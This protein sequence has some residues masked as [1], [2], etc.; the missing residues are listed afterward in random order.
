MG[1]NYEFDIE[2]GESGK[3]R[4]GLQE[5]G[6]NDRTYVNIHSISV[7]EAGTSSVAAIEAGSLLRYDRATQTIACPDA[8]GRLSVVNA[9]GVEML[10][11]HATDASVNVGS[12]PAGLYIAVFTNRDGNIHTLQFIK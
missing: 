12:L 3:M 7:I 5:M 11:C 1:T 8:D 10:N 2:L 9:A 4:I 6:N